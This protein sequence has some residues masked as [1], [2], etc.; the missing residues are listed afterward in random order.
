MKSLSSFL[1]YFSCFK[2]IFFF[3]KML[4]L[5]PMPQMLSEP[6]YPERGICFYN[7]GSQSIRFRLLLFKYNS[8]PVLHAISLVCFHR[9][10]SVQESLIKFRKIGSK[11]IQ[12]SALASF[13]IC[14]IRD[15]STNIKQYNLLLNVEARYGLRHGS[16]AAPVMRLFE[17]R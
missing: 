16:P 5:L 12:C 1:F 8:D 3:D 17:R 11:Y 2:T 6:K 14:F 15:S 10:F 9:I 4:F 13:G 7:T